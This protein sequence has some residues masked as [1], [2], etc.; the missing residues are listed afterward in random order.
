MGAREE[1]R[2]EKKEVLDFT[3][4]YIFKKINDL[5]KVKLP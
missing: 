4:D 3:L 2:K 5:I 1:R